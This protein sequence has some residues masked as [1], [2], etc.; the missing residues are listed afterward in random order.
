MFSV[1]KQL[2]YTTAVNL[3]T[4]SEAKSATILI[5]SALLSEH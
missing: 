5:K 3:L 2:L 1:I 4:M